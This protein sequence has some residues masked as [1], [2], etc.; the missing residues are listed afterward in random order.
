M[1]QIMM[2]Q[3]LNEALRE[4]MKRDETVFVLGE[5]VQGGAFLVTAALVP[6]FGT[7]R[8]MDTPLS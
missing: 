4:E 3:A 7:D 6:E 5:G 1:R 2:M 8:V